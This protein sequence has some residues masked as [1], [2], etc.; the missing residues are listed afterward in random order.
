MITAFALVVL[1]L[2]LLAWIGQVVS[3][4]SPKLAVRWGLTEPESDVDA[5]FYADVRAE[6]AWDALTLWTL[7]AAAI[8]LLLSAQAWRP[9]GLIGGGM[10]LY[11]AGRGI[12]QRL[13]MRRRGIAVGKPSTVKS[14][15]VLLALWGLAGAA[16]IA[17]AS[18]PLP[19]W[20]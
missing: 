17:L 6:C 10:Y 4:T 16:T 7:T 12:A 15:Y 20:S 18:H 2:S 11:F 13:T 5:A 8:L 14:A 19:G 1:L 9:F 3:A